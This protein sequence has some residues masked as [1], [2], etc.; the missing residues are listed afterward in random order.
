MGT[1]LLKELFF[2]VLEDLFI[3]ITNVFITQDKSQK[4]T[5]MGTSSLFLYRLLIV[6]C[7][8][9]LS[10]RKLITIRPLIIALQTIP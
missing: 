1:T 2:V 10:I 8:K 7:F 9:I 4:I 5:A 6:N 3:K